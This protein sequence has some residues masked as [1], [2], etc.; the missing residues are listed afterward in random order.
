MNF[1]VLSAG[2]SDPGY[3]QYNV[4]PTSGAQYYDGRAFTDVHDDGTTYCG[5]AQAMPA[6]VS[7]KYEHKTGNLVK[8]QA[9][10]APSLSK[11][12]QP[13]NCYEL[14]SV[15]M[16]E[17]TPF[18][19]TSYVEVPTATAYPKNIFIPVAVT[20]ATMVESKFIR[21]GHLKIRAGQV[22]HVADKNNL[23]KLDKDLPLGI[24]MMDDDMVLPGTSRLLMIYVSN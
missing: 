13:L 9:K 8:D 3:G 20:G 6:V 22:L 7:L 18:V 12:T 11:D 1:Q 17:K 19:V 24:A 10:Y 23:T 4:G 15:I 21:G 5:Q 2:A 16:Q 14:G